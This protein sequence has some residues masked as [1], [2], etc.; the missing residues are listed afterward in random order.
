MFVFK[1]QRGLCGRACSLCQCWGLWMSQALSGVICWSVEGLMI[2]LG[3]SAG[4]QELGSALWIVSQGCPLSF[5]WQF[6]FSWVLH[7]ESLLI[8]LI[9][10][11]WTTVWWLHWEGM[12]RWGRDYGGINGNWKYIVKKIGF[13]CISKKPQNN[14]DVNTT[15]FSLI[16][17]KYRDRWFLSGGFPAWGQG[18]LHLS[19]LS[20]LVEGFLLP[21]HFVIP[22]GWWTLRQFHCIP[23]RMKRARDKREPLPA[24]LALLKIIVLKLLTTSIYSPWP[25]CSVIEY[26][27]SR[28]NEKCGFFVEK[29]TTSNKIRVHLFRKRGK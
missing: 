5:T 3:T 11:L 14:I 28:E 25:E 17:N 29:I 22:D 9:Y 6:L 10:Q 23:A 4:C 26:L 19:S 12:G 16:G 8:L 27:A 20:S 1:P 24:E 15:H 18:H 7:F 2:S 13:S 21:G